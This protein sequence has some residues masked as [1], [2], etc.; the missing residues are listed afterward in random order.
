MKLKGTQ[1]I[2]FNLS[3]LACSLKLQESS[4]EMDNLL[5]Q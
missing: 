5:K 3:F 1:V 2:L 4:A